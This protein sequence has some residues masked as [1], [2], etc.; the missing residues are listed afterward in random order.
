MKIVAV[1]QARMGSTRLP[2]KVMMPIGDRPMIGHILDRLSMSQELDE[3]IVATSGNDNNHALIDYVKRLGFGVEVGSEID[4][5][6]RYLGAA[7]NRM[8][9]VVVRITG[10]CPFV[11]PLLVDEAIQV[12]KTAEIDYLSNVEVPT[13]PDGLDIEVFSY[14]ALLKSSL[15][16]LTSSQREHVTPHLRES[17]KF[18]TKSITNVDDYSWIR[19]TVDQIEDIQVVRNVYEHFFPR[20]NFGWEEVLLLQLNRPQLFEANSSIRRNQG[21]TMNTGQKIWSRAKRVIPGGNMLLS[22][23]PEMFLPEHWPT[24]FSKAKGC[25]VWDLDNR[26]FIDMSTMGVGTNIL[27]YGNEKVDNE[28]IK[29]IGLGNM[30][31]LNCAEEVYLAEELVRLHPWA[32]MVRLARTGGE[33][34]AIAMRIGRAASGRDNVAVCGYHGWHDWYL[35]ANLADDRSLDGH[36]L[37][38]LNPTGVPRQLK[39]TIYPFKYNDI[40]ELESLIK[41]NNIGVIKMEVVRNMQPTNG[42]LSRVRQLATENNIVLIFDE[43]TSGFRETFG[44][45]HLKY[46]VNPDLA[47]FGKALGNGYAITAIIGKADI[48]QAAQS[49][50]ISSTFW[51]ERIGPTA[52]L[53]TLEQMELL[54]SW[55][56]ITNTGLQI[57]DGWKQLSKTYDIE[58]DFFGIAALS[59]FNFKGKNALIYKTFLTQEMLHK[60]FLAGNSVYASIAHTP[61]IVSEYLEALESIFK[62]INEC[63]SGRDP[64]LLLSGPVCHDNFKRLN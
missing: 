60:G 15:D 22:K 30:S 3:I 17:K 29:N 6:Q 32:E 64:G 54:Q 25:R 23:R 5:L 55:E 24:Y 48:M 19:W 10:D 35:A 38:G 63:E 44:G 34:N 2:N 36:L 31:T 11:D 59:G 42:F 37:P 62:V 50:F 12:F 27:G 41:L 7:L 51:T 61:M 52:G 18:K 16:D 8:A 47:V 53:K 33:A 14:S 21:A 56:V 57:R 4:V 13:F 9:D 40:D 58:L 1:V 45:L 46:G 26:E 20:T 28:V 43:C 49:T 39:G